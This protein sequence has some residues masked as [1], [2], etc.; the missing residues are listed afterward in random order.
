MK[1]RLLILPA[2]LLLLLSSCRSN[3]DTARRDIDHGRIPAEFPRYERQGEFGNPCTDALMD[4]AYSWI[5]TPYTYGGHTK[6]GTD[7]SGLVLSLYNDILGIKLPRV[8]REQGEYCR[9]I[10]KSDLMPGDLIF[11]A[12]GSKNKVNHVGMYVGGGRMI[13]AS[14]SQGV[15]ESDISLDYYVRHFHHAGKVDEYHRL[16]AQAARTADNDKRR[17]QKELAM[18]ETDK[19]KGKNKPEADVKKKEPPTRNNLETPATITAAEFASLTARKAEAARP[20]RT[21]VEANACP[22]VDNAALD[23]IREIQ[24]DTVHLMVFADIYR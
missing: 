9:K 24:A 17:Q 14:A 21:G 5:G 1:F 18:A 20:S 23:S 15:M 2:I 19:K 22:A 10:K 8:S 12:I 11:F 7:C 6:K 13:H 3:R 16:V 4:A